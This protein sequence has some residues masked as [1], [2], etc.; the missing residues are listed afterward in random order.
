MVFEIVKTPPDS[1]EFESIRYPK[2]SESRDLMEYDDVLDNEMLDYNGVSKVMKKTGSYIFNMGLVNFFEYLIIN[3]LLILHVDKRQRA[4][5]SS[6]REIT[7][8]EANVRVIST[9]NMS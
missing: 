7:F 3:L 8:I 1:R 2:R 9:L 4:I 5:L 6:G